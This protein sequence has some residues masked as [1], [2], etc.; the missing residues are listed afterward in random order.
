[1]A[2]S[3]KSQRRAVLEPRKIGGF[4][5]DLEKQLGVTHAR[6]NE[7]RE[8]NLAPEVDWW[9]EGTSVAFSAAAVEKM[10][11]AL[12]VVLPPPP[13]PVQALLRAWRPT[14]NK[15]ILLAY[16]GEKP[17]E[18]AAGLLRVRVRPGLVFKRHQPIPCRHEQAD[19]WVLDRSLVFK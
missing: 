19:L 10:R 15:H 12:Q 14:L 1:M 9:M 3:H 17:P 8:A 6:M 2:T 7:W 13:A 16:Q 4:Q 11:A 18:T 5:A